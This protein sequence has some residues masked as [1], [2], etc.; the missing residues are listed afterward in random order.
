MYFFF[1]ILD[2]LFYCLVLVMVVSFW[3]WMFVYGMF[4]FFYEIVFILFFDF[5]IMNFI[6]F[7]FKGYFLFWFFFIYGLCSFCGE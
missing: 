4:G 7:I 5:V 1:I 6:D 3:V 2:Y